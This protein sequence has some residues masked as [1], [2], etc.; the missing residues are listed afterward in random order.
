MRSWSINDILKRY[1]ASHGFNIYKEKFQQMWRDGKGWFFLMRPI[2][3]EYRWYCIYDVLDLPEVKDKIAAE[4]TH[5]EVEL[6][7]WV[8]AQ[9]V[10]FGYELTKPKKVE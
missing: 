5:W 9:Y 6:G 2:D 10:A 4:M 8:S 3:P 1:S 7:K